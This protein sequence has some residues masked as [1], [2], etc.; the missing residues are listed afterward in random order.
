MQP[1]VDGVGVRVKTVGVSVGWVVGVVG[2]GVRVAKTVGVRV[3]VG[4]RLGVQ[5]RVAVPVKVGVAVAGVG[6]GPWSP[7]AFVRRTAI[8]PRVFVPSGQ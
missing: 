4:V 2:G 5:V 8:C 7:K 1:V 3:N 6:E